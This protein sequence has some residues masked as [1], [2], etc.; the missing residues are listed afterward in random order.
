MAISVRGARHS[1]GS[2]SVVDFEELV[3][4]GFEIWPEI[5]QQAAAAER[6][7]RAA[8]LAGDVD[9][10]SAALA[11]WIDARCAAAAYA[12]ITVPHETLRSGMQR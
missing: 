9:A 1:L 3:E 4:R 5:A 7:I 8:L 2:C 11:D 10:G 6:R 12:G